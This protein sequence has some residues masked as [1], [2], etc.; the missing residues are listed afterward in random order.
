MRTLCQARGEGGTGT[1]TRL[2]GDVLQDEGPADVELLFGDAPA[3][4]RVA[5]QPHL[6]QHGQGDPP[7]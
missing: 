4:V 1:R 7:P 6:P 3:P 5:L 2:T